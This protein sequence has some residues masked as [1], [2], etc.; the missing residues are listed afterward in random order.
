MRLDDINEVKI[1]IIQID[2][3]SDMY[4]ISDIITEYNERNKKNR[5]ISQFVSSDF[6]SDKLEELCRH[7]NIINN[8]KHHNLKS[9]FTYYS[10]KKKKKKRSLYISCAFGNPVLM[11]VFIQWCFPK[12]LDKSNGIAYDWMSKKFDSGTN[13]SVEMRNYLDWLERVND[14]LIKND[15]LTFVREVSIIMKLSKDQTN[16]SY[17]ETIRLNK[18]MIQCGVE[19]KDRVIVL[20]RFFK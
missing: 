7:L 17:R 12:Y 20:S 2:E 9:I 8:S 14:D 1:G 19:Y 5:S 11:S 10:R 15:P 3:V 18:I 6:G 4:S 16:D 13:D